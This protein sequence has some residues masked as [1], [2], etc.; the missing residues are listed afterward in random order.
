MIKL[1]PET[2]S[3]VARING[4]VS[5]P[6][7]TLNPLTC[8]KMSSTELIALAASVLFIILFT[9]RWKRRALLLP[10]GP[11][12][13]PIFGNLFDVPKESSWLTYTEW[14]KTYGDVMSLRVFGQVIVVLN[15]EKSAREFLE[16]RATIYSGRP[17][18]PFFELLKWSDWNMAFFSDT[19]LWRQRRRILDR[20]LRP[21]AAVQYWPIQ[22]EKV[23]DFLKILLSNPEDFRQHI[24]YLQGTIIMSSVYG[25]DVKDHNDTYLRDAIDANLLGQKALLPG[26]I[27]VNSFPFL[28][29]FP[30]WLPG[31]GF[32][33]L[34][35][36]GERIGHDMLHRPFELVK[37]RM[38]S[39]T[40]RPCITQTN[41]LELEEANSADFK[42][43]ECAIAEA[44]G[45]LYL[46]G[47]DTTAAAISTL[48]LALTLYPDVQRRAQVE[49]DV[50]TE[51][52][53]LPNYEDRNRLPY[54]GAVCKEVLRWRMVAP[55]GV[56]HTST[57]DD[58]FEG[59][60]IPKGTIV[61]ANTW[62]ILRDPNVFPDPDEFKPERFLTH[63]GQLRDDP[64]L[65]A[66]FGFGKRI[67]PGRHLAED[68]LSIV[69]ASLLATY[70]IGKAKDAQGHEIA[71]GRGYTG[72]IISSPKEFKCSIAPRSA[73]AKALI[74][75]QKW[76]S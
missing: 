70:S 18:L 37:D 1:S 12:P 32:H 17:A 45:S 61:I 36:E 6:P 23:H 54:V 9:Q 52:K 40:V 13:L 31:M 21:S 57:Q 25:Y 53:R 58:V 28:K 46:A 39:G 35:R 24:K 11:R 47:A 68:T 8:V 41:L 49:L 30:G 10:P 55:A 15:S 64:T 5:Y 63:S 59:Y 74:A 44:A 42:E 7:R 56:P 62:A 67:C 3:M 43:A 14:A 22:Q 16:K 2:D 76:N 48:F 72:G 69:A 65:T 71:V 66:V 29:H 26:G 73:A 60:F 19:V 20:G 51:G 34:A 33:A 27:I 38:R 50:I 4:T 75:A